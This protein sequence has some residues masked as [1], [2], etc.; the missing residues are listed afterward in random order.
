MREDNNILEETR[1]F[2]SQLSL[3]ENDDCELSHRDLEILS[4]I[5]EYNEYLEHPENFE[6]SDTV[7]LD[8]EESGLSFPIDIPKPD[9]PSTPPSK[10]RALLIYPGNTKTKWE[11]YKNFCSMY[12]KILSDIQSFNNTIYNFIDFYLSKLQ[13]L[14]SNNYASALHNFLNHP[15]AIKLIANP[16]TDTGLFTNADSVTLRYIPRETLKGSGEFKIYEYYEVQSLQTLLKTDFYK[17]LEAGYII[18]RCEYCGRFFCLIK[19]TT[20]NTATSLLPIIRITPA[21]SLAITTKE[22]KKP[23]QTIQRRSRLTAVTSV[24]TRT[25]PDALLRQKKEKSFTQRLKI[26][27]TTLKSRREFQMKNLKNLLLLEIFI[28]SAM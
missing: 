26:Y 10:A 22:L 1:Q 8:N 23:L 9:I 2:T 19:H 25:Y 17:A 28:I 11:Y 7:Y 27:I 21:L 16:I 20:L 15:S 24:L 13:K 5:E 14:N 18:R 4:Q 3:F 12:E 6:N